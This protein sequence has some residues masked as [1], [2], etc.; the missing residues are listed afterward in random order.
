M[1]DA[2]GGRRAD[3]P[4]GP[5]GDI[6]RPK[7]WRPSSAISVNRHRQILIWPLILRLD[8]GTEPQ[9]DSRGRIAAAVEETE[10]R[11]GAAGT[12]VWEPVDDLLDHAGP[13]SETFPGSGLMWELEQNEAQ[14]YGEFVYFY[15]FLQKSLFRPAP[16]SDEIPAF[17]VWRR[18]GVSG[19]RVVVDAGGRGLLRF[20]PIVERLNLYLFRVGAAVLVLELDFASTVLCAPPG[21]AWDKA[22]WGSESAFLADV[23][24]AVDK[25]RRVYTPYFAVRHPSDPGW[26]K[27][28]PQGAP[29]A[30]SWIDDHGQA[31]GHAGL[32]AERRQRAC[33]DP[34]AA[35]CAPPWTPDQLG[36]AV[37]RLRMGA[38]G[39][40]KKRRRVSPLADHWRQ[41]LEPL[42]V[43]GYSPD[44]DRPAG[45]EA[46][47]AVWRHILDE[48][49]PV[50]SYVS[51]TGAASRVGKGVTN[52]GNTSERH[53]LWLVS[54]GDWVRLCAADPPGTDRLP[55]APHFLADFEKDSCYDRFFPSSS[56]S[57]STR[58]LFAG[59]HFGVV[60]S[61]PYFDRLISH[62][63]RRH[64][65]QMAL[66]A[67][68]ELA[69]LLATS[70]RITAAVARLEEH[71]VRGGK[72]GARREE[73]RNELRAIQEDFLA[74][75]HR[76]RFTDVSNQIQ[77]TELY[78]KW[79]QSMR[80]DELYADV[81]DELA[82][83]V[84]FAMTD[85][86][87]KTGRDAAHLS[88][89]ATLGLPVALALSFMPIWGKLLENT[90]RFVKSQDGKS[91][92]VVS[93]WGSILWSAV[94][95]LA[96]VAATLFA[97][98]SL[99]RRAPAPGDQGEDDA[100]LHLKLYNGGIVA[101]IAAAIGLLVLVGML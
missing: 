56:T 84:G 76:F 4:L 42:V 101:L 47:R 7:L 22:E 69:A 23:Q 66:L 50:M 59:Y 8:D 16:S 99:M 49:I 38:T 64:Y 63:F 54:R 91:V 75:V 6:Y 24:H 15:D 34:A 48:R 57:E 70:S 62:H 93:V 10:S 27:S 51:L 26:I 35:S 68:M 19:C 5:L 78:R 65:F 94:P 3:D 40:D 58:Y 36:P 92:E 9:S 71:K 33:E 88:K 41:I 46:P 82:A 1:S 43:A 85:E 29:L 30:F 17:R 77:P 83:A 97:V 90:D 37:R 21:S 89:I 74:F 25:I 60:G 13:L 44:V 18:K 73:F 61:G 86:Q 11:L 20:D 45:S 87:A 81:K 55:Y 53:D 2:A 31:I 80:L 39:A 32:Q 67:N 96:V 95:L 98:G 100:P 14:T 12:D 28:G 52:T 72:A 79:R